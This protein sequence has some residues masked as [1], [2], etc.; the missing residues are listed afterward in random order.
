MI[1]EG[2]RYDGGI[3]GKEPEVDGKVTS[4]HVCWAVGFVHLLVEDTS[5][6]GDIEDIVRVTKSIES[7]VPI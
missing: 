4:G 2:I 7:S 5:I 6:I 3:S 1:Q